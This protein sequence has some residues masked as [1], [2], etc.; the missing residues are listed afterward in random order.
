MIKF[1]ADYSKGHRDTDQA[2]RSHKE[3]S[4]NWKSIWHPRCFGRQLSHEKHHRKEN[5][6]RKDD[7]L[8]AL[9]WKEES[10]E[11]EKSADDAWKH[12]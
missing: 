1:Q 6:D 10:A 11:D 12:F 3:L 4:N 9:S 8:T 5:R 2:A 7:F